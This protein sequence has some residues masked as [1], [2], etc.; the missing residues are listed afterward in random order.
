MAAADFTAVDSAVAASVAV[1]PHSIVAVV[2]AAAVLVTVTAASAVTTAVAIA[3]AT[4]TGVIFTVGSTTG[5]RTIHAVAGSSGP[6][7]ARAE[8]VAPGG[9]ATGEAS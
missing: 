2:F 8:S 3:T 4:S 6:I 5:R 1:V 9:I 7:T